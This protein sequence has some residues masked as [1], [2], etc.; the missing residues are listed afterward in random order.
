VARARGVQ[1]QR[2]ARAR[3]ALHSPASRI[4]GR[5][6]ADSGLTA[7]ALRSLRGLSTPSRSAGRGR[8]RRTGS[9]ASR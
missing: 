8:A 2:V 6:A 1:P 4:R 9:R 5:S 7:T 3:G